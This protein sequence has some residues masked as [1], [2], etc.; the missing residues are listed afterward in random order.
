VAAFHYV[1]I[2][3]KGEKQKGII[4]AESAKHARQLLRDKSLTPIEVNPTQ[5]KKTSERF[6]FLR[7]PGMTSKE[8]TLMTRQ[9]ATLLSAGLPIE[10]V[11][12]TV[13]EQTEKPRAKGL[14]LSVRSK[15]VEGHSLATALRDFP[16][17][18]SNLYC[19]TVA[20]G[21]KSGHLDVV[22][23]RLADYTEQQ[24]AMRRKIQNALIYPS[25]M[26]LVSIGIVGFLLEY[27]VPR[28]VSV[29]S[30]IGQALPMMTQLLIGF[31]TGIE[32]Y[33]LYIL[34]AFIVI[35]FLFRRN[36][37]NNIAFKEKI[38]TLLL[39]IPIIGNAIKVAN[40]A[41]FSRTFAILS[42]A[43]VSVL[44]AMS[45]SSQLIT[46]LPIRKSVEAAAKRVREGANIHL[47]LKQTHYFPPMSIH[48][49]ASGEASG[50]LEN[51]L[52]RAANNQDNEITSLIETS[53]TLFEPMIILLMG[54][55]V[56][57][58]VLAVLLPIFQL[59][60]FT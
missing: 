27:V 14:I 38:H 48:L 44:E 59:D 58:I 31:S 8:L 54:A 33:G 52:E 24:Y 29:Y 11:L 42:S 18:F 7:K 3:S 53:L 46:N 39:R 17:A 22:L 51:M 9:F 30:N 60:Q 25:I 37:K 12:T 45:I 55:I 19:S 50:Q 13:A 34:I 2:N 6:T 41:R 23:Q 16:E 10:E 49:I 28:M 32:K 35:V 26:V 56:L 21:E 15:V 47:A 1:A 43:G 20:A 36:M 4:E 5:Q 57:F 40:T